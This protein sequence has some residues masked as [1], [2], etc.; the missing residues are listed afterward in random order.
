MTRPVCVPSYHGF[1]FC[2]EDGDRYVPDADRRA[3]L[4]EDPSCRFDEVVVARQCDRCGDHWWTQ[5]RGPAWVC[6][7]CE[8]M[9]NGWAQTYWPGR[10]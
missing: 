1:Y 8:A 9:Q 7:C 3:V 4:Q 5:D 2:P 6:D 10:A